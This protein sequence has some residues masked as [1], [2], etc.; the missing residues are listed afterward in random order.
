MVTCFSTLS[1]SFYHQLHILWSTVE[2]TWKFVMSDFY[3]GLKVVL[4]CP[5]VLI[6]HCYI[7]FVIHF[8][9]MSLF[10]SLILSQCAKLFYF[11][12]YIMITGQ[13]WIQTFF[14]L[15]IS[16]LFSSANQTLFVFHIAPFKIHLN[17]N[18]CNDVTES[19]SLCT[20]LVYYCKPTYKYARSS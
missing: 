9:A 7:C 5:T 2:E 3:L 16:Q 12:F 19:G 10:A 20:N 4:F 18:Q 1:R 13:K 6:S 14:C 8:Q 17:R 11:I 15:I